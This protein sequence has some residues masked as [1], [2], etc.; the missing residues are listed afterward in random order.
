MKK[1]FIRLSYTLIPVWLLLVGMVIYLNVTDVSSEKTDINSGDLMRLGMIQ[2]SPGYSDS[3]RAVYELPEQYYENQDND[4]LLHLDTCDIVVVGDSYSHGGGIGQKGDYVNYLAHESGRRVVVFAPD[5]IV[6]NPVQ[7]AYELLNLNVIDSTNV[8]NLVVEEVERQLISRHNSFVNNH[9]SLPRPKVKK[10]PA[11]TANQG[12]IEKK[13]EKRKNFSPLL[14]VRD[15]V[16]YNLFDKN[17]VYFAKLSK[18][19]FSVEDPTALYFYEED[20]KSER[21]FLI[22]KHK[23]IVD[24][25]RQLID[26]AR[27]K[28]IN[29]II[30]VAC[31]K[32]DLYQDFIIDNH[33]PEKTINEDIAKWMADDLDRFVITKQLLYPRVKQGEKDVFLYN[34]THWSPVSSQIV[35]SE[36]IKKLK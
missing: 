28:G 24:V 36:I 26:K 1:F 13:K 17:P 35:V 32:Y 10:Q 31:D 27:E 21:S 5:N 15:Y 12:E 7:I 16:F 14:R 2:D 9:T 30:V 33:Y 22:D 8:K 34:D 3:I 11:P 23:V 29:L 25:Y 4:S 19:L 18:P 6:G 20:V